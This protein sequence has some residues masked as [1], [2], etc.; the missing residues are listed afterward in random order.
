MTS[1]TSFHREQRLLETKL[2][3]L[4]MSRRQFNAKN[5]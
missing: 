3:L 1:L 2:S 5:E 4:A